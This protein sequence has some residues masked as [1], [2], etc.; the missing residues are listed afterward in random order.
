MGSGSR[1]V[2]RELSPEDD[3]NGGLVISHLSIRKA[4]DLISEGT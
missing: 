4:K 2:G 3:R 1:P